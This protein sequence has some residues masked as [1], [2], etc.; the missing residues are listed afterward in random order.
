VAAAQGI[1]TDL[2]HDSITA[3]AQSD[4]SPLASDDAD[5]DEMFDDRQT[6]SSDLSEKDCPKKVLLV[7]DNPINL[8]VLFAYMKKLG[9]DFESATNGQEAVDAYKANPQQFSGVLMD[10][11]MPV[12]DGL[13]ATRL[14]R[15]YEREGQLA[16]VPVLALT[17][18]ASESACQ[19]ALKSGVDVFLTKPMRFNALSDVLESMN[20][21]PPGGVVNVAAPNTANGE[22]PEVTA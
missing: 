15:A 6:S 22:L 7:D 11:S 12:M 5:M 4:T 14:I 13:E 8:K 2:T 10:I 9:C 17:G 16:A 19:E 3:N 18:L 1:S 20:I 21:F